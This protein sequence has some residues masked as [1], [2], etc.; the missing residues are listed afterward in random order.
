MRITYSDNLF[1]G[2]AIWFGM[3]T[4]AVFCALGVASFLLL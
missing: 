1:V 4:A 3:R 2:W